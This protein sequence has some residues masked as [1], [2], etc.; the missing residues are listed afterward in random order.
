MEHTYLKLNDLS[1]KITSEIEDIINKNF[2]FIKVV[3]IAIGED[4]STLSYIRGMQKKACNI[5]IEIE[6]MTYPIEISLEEFL[7]EI[8]RMNADDTIHG[9]IVQ[10]PLPKHIDIKKVSETLRYEKDL[11]G[12]TF[13]NQGLL[14]SGKPFLVPATAWACDLTLQYIK[15]RYSYELSGKKCVV[16]GRSITV[17]KPVFHLMLQRDLTPTIIHTKSI[18]KENITKDADVVIAS[19]GV[20]ELVNANWLKEGSVVLDV[21]IHSLHCDIDKTF[22]LCGDVDAASSLKKAMIVT[23]VPGGI[24][25]VTTSL[26]FA[27]ALKSYYKIVRNE[28]IDFEFLKTI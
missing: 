18:D 27:N 21:G 16:I 19:C 7:E 24:G 5:G 11:D 6:S 1:D 26:L 15:N 3:N 22:K 25:V 23:A 12:I 2:L 4:L 9:I 8:E 20:P 14:F 17:G 10:T 13:Y 28:I